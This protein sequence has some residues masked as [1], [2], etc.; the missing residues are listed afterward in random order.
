[1]KNQIN[2]FIV[3]ITNNVITHLCCNEFAKKHK[4]GY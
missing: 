3:M 2:N 4:S 1:M